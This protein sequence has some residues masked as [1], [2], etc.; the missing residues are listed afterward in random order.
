[1]TESV[2]VI[3]PGRLGTVLAARLSG[4]GYDVVA[5]AG[6][7]A[8]GLRRFVTRLP[9]AEVTDAA[10]AAR[11]AR[12]VLLCVPDDAVESLVH[13][14][15]RDEA[16]GPGSKVVHTAG[17]LGVCVLASAR[18]AGARVAACHPAQTFPDAAAGPEVLDGVAWAVT[19][20]RSDQGWA[21]QLVRDLGGTPQLVAEE[22]RALYHAGLVTG[23]N[24][25]SAVV[26]L[27]GDL[28][29]GA[30]VTEPAVFLR[31]LVCASAVN[32]AER[33]AAALTGPVRRGDAATV[34]RHLAEVDRVLPEAGG[35]Y[36]A[37][38]LLAVGL[39]R[40][41]GL[42]EDAAVAVA[43]ALQ[44]PGEGAC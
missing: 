2:A 37:V 26:A 4:A 23:A 39:A 34:R 19:A 16:V 28:L 22:S 14:L 6:R 9:D 44:A 15:A 33:G 43:K 35:V 25:T 3:G 24:F 27:A 11:R 13:G 10:A 31:P 42:D 41:A 20:R 29:R 8:A 36:R 21:Q 1:M 17:A 32:A 12:L 18:L 30:G 38:S 40:R 7:G 5:V